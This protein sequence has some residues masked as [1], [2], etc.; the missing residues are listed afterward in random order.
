M[1]CGFTR[2]SSLCRRLRPVHR[3]MDHQMGNRRMVP[4][5]FI[6]SQRRLRGGGAY[7]IFMG[8]R[9]DFGALDGAGRRGSDTNSLDGAGCRLRSFCAFFRCLLVIGIGK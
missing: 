5:G 3:V 8:N 9:A 1:P 2:S 7:A 4:N 6:G